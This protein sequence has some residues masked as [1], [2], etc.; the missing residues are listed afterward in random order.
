[1]GLLLQSSEAQAED[2]WLQRPIRCFRSPVILSSGPDRY[3]QAPLCRQYACRPGVLG[4]AV[5]LALSRKARQ[6]GS[7]GMKQ[8]GLEV[9]HISYMIIHCTLHNIGGFAQSSKPSIHV[10]ASSGYLPWGDAAKLWHCSGRF[11]CHTLNT[12]ST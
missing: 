10:T 9:H 1:M 6:V 8:Q 3:V 7:N 2:V 12:R 5:Q 11:Q 4:S